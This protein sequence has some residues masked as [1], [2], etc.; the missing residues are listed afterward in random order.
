MVGDAVTLGEADGIGDEVGAVVVGSDV[1]GSDV[2]GGTD[3]EGV[4]IGAGVNAEGADVGF[5]ENVGFGDNVGFNDNATV[6]AKVSGS[7]VDFPLP[8]QNMV[9]GDRRNFH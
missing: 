5:F 3:F 8:L 1:G 7:V 6:G 9:N 4:G 2:V